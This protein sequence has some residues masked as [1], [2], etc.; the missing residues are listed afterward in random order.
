MSGTIDRAA[1]RALAEALPSGSAVPLPREWVLQ[2]ADCGEP[3]TEPA[4][5]ADRLLTAKQVAERLQLSHEEV[6][7]Q[8]KRWPF[9]RK[10]GPRTLRFSEA[11]L[12][13]WLDRRR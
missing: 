10:L 5:T 7:R 8:A 11:G 13:R 4:P 3:V 9:T 12:N 1:L 6:Y 2:L